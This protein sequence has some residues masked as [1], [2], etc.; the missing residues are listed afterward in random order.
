MALERKDAAKSALR[1][2]VF[3]VYELDQA[4]ESTEEVQKT[5][6]DAQKMVKLFDA[7][8]K[9]RDAELVTLD[10]EDKALDDALEALKNL[11]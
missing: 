7:E 10:E 11:C 9:R 4:V 5:R 3:K 8:V 2:A 1:E 6:A